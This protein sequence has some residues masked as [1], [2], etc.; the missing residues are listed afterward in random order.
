MTKR[1]ALIT[2]SASG[3][4]VQTVLALAKQGCH[5]AINYRHSEE[6]AMKLKERVEVTYDVQCELVRG[7]IAKQED[8]QRIAKHTM[9]LYGQIDILINNA[10][11]YIFERK[12]MID[13]SREEWE[14]IIHGNLSSVFY[15]A[16]EIVPIMRERRW[17]RIINFGFNQANQAP[18]WMY[19]SAF[20][21]A[22]VGLVSLTKTLAQEEACHGITVNMVCPGDIVG[23]NKEKFIREIRND[24]TSQAT[25]PVGREGTGEDI[26]RVIS[27]LTEADSDFIT[28]SVIEVSGGADVLRKRG[29]FL[30]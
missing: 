26:A 22:K 14:Q 15:L 28:G 21:A 3:L 17:G 6:K 7:D 29:D 13:Y 11:P 16:K 10:G 12:K 25:A 1:V 19:R 4:G 23:K 2:G 24:G 18:G 20:A 8:C 27:F 5:L 9:D 30:S